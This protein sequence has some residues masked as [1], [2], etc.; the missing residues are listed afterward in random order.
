[1]TTPDP[2][3][4]VRLQVS[5]AELELLRVALRHLLVS[6]DDAETIEELKV[7]IARLASAA[8]IDAAAGVAAD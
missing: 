8:E 7:L 3:H 5:R 6:E 4:P 1:M 2:D